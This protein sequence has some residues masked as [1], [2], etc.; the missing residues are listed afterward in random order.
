M[1][2]L[3]LSNYNYSIFSKFLQLPVAA[4]STTG[5][6]QRAEFKSFCNP[7]GWHGSCMLSQLDVARTWKNAVKQ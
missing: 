3:S 2:S 1:K 7:I 4:A 6:N 5:V